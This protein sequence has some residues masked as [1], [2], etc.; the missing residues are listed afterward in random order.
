M[1]ARNLYPDR[2]FADLYDELT[3][4]VELRRT[5][6]ANDKTVMEADGLIKVVEGKNMANWKL[7]SSKTFWDVRGNDEIDKLI[8]TVAVC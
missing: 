5:H 7:G 3:M 8:Q 2:S 6:Q 4:P 1:D